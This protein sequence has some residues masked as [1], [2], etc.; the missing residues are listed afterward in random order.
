MS[1]QESLQQQEAH[2]KKPIPEGMKME[3]K[4]YKK[5][6]GGRLMPWG[7]GCV[8]KG[9]KGFVFLGGNTA[10]DENY[11]PKEG[12]PGGGGVL[13]D[14]AAQWRRILENIKADLEEM[15][16]SLESIVKMT[17]YVKGPFPEGVLKSPN[18]RL[19]V[20]D[21]FFREHCPSL[22]SDDNP[23]PSE[24]IGVSGFAHPDMVVEIVCIAAIPDD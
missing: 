22:C 1:K 19:D 16:S 4:T 14:P 21:A 11:A 23:P 24:L 17:Y 20:M 8:V 13:K 18:H 2:V 3:K 10:G 9:A 6:I 12:Y 15:G 7:K 5:Y